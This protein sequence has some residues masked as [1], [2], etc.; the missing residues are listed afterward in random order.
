MRETARLRLRRLRAADEAALVTLDSDPEVMRHVGS[1]RG[2]R[3]PE[4]TVARVRQRI[5]ADHGAAGWWVIEGKH[6][7]VIH[8]VGLLLPVPDGEDIEVGYRLARRSWGRGF[9][10]EAAAALIEHAFTALALPRVVAVTYPDNHPSRRVLG[11]LGFTH[12]GSRSY[13]GARVE[14]FVL[15]AED[16][17]RR[18]VDKAGGASP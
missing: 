4:E 3:T 15:A 18:R 14:H 6:D 16:W 7:G 5:A 12:E 8:G 10:T 2:T 9:A 1:P 13:R 11:K 17:R